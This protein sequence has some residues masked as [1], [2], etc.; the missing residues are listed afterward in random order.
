MY[1]YSKEFYQNNLSGIKW[2]SYISRHVASTFLVAEDSWTFLII[3][4]NR[5]TIQSPKLKPFYTI[6]FIFN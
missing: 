6:L 2:R 3:N 1:E 4:L 5:S